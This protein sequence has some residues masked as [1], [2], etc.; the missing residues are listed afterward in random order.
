M[1]TDHAA[2]KWLFGVGNLS[3]RIARWITKLNEYEFTVE[4]K[5]GKQ[6]AN[7]D[8]LSRIPPPHD[9]ETVLAMVEEGPES[10]VRLSREAH[11]QCGHGQMHANHD[12]SSSKTQLDQHDAR[13]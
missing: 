1:I 3:E 6:H 12:N 8:A 10:Y 5:P 2:L 7:A 13:H 4:Y 9:E 11:A